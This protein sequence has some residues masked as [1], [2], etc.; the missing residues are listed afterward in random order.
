MRID[1]KEEGIEG[2]GNGIE[3]ISEL[4]GKR[5]EVAFKG[6]P[7]FFYGVKIRRIGR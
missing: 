3:E 4:R 2:G 7:R 5:F 6:S 1:T